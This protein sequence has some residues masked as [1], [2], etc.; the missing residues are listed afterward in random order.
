MAKGNGPLPFFTFSDAGV[1]IE[2]ATRR[3]SSIEKALC[4]WPSE[5]RVSASLTETLEQFA[6]GSSLNN[7]PFTRSAD[8]WFA[9][10]KI[11]A[12]TFVPRCL[13]GAKKDMEATRFNRWRTSRPRS[14]WQPFQA[15]N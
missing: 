3:A 7:T 12:A 14:P 13:K 11:R 10:N 1:L 9:G 6:I 5:S 8:G 2:L 4:P 15:F